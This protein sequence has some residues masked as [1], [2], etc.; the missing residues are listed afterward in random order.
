MNRPS[1]R[2]KFVTL[3][4]HIYTPYTC[5]HFYISAYLALSIPFVTLIAKMCNNVKEL[6]IHNK[7]DAWDAEYMHTLFSEREVL[8]AISAIQFP[9]PIKPSSEKGAL[10]INATPK[11]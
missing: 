2:G 1:F 3:V 11:E 10:K 8:F 4:E 9:N 5:R 7:R 6:L